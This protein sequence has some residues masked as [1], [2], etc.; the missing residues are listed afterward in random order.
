MWTFFLTT[1]NV[2]FYSK[3]FVVLCG[4]TT[5]YLYFVAKTR[6]LLMFVIKYRN[7]IILIDY[8]SGDCIFSH[9]ITLI[10]VVEINCVYH[11]ARN[12]L[13]KTKRQFLN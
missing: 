13:I 2:S 10:F 12:F 9:G 4:M 6:T 11:Q 3:L 5:F 1:T 7:N 8:I